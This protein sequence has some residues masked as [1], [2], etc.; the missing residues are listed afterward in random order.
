[1]QGIVV[2]AEQEL[3]R[4]QGEETLMRVELAAHAERLTQLEAAL[5]KK[6][7]EIS[8]LKLTTRRLEEEL[9]Q[10]KVLVEE[11]FDAAEQKTEEVKKALEDRFMQQLTDSPDTDNMLFLRLTL[12][13]C[14]TSAV[15]ETIE[16]FIYTCLNAK[17]IPALCVKQPCCADGERSRTS[18]AASQP[19]PAR[20]ERRN[21]SRTPA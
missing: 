18:L 2:D 12:D 20:V 1:M 19:D 14:L 8:V 7:Q 6:D 16:T 3:A 10:L 13:E 21:Q 4:A 5:E 15:F 11:G 9:N 17:T